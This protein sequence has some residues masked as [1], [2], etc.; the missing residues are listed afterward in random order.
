MTIYQNAMKE[1]CIALDLTGRVL[2]GLSDNAEGINGTLA[3]GKDQVSCYTYAM[4]GK[5]WCI[6][7]HKLSLPSHG[8]EGTTKSTS[9][10]NQYSHLLE[11]FFQTCELF[12]QRAKVP[13]PTVGSE[14]DF[15]W[16][17]SDSNEELFPDLQIKVVKEIISTGG[18][19]SS[20]TIDETSKDYLTPEEW[21]HEMKRLVEEND[22]N[23]GDNRNSNDTILIDCRNHKEYAVGHFDQAI[24]PN[25][26]IFA[27]FPKWVQENKS[28][29]KDKKV[30]MYCTGGI[31]CEKAS[32]YIRNELKD[33]SST[34]SV[35]HLQG[36]IHKY[37]DKFAGDGYFRGKNFVF[38][39]RL[40]MDAEEHKKKDDSTTTEVV[41]EKQQNCV[42]KCQYCEGNYDNFTGDRVCTVCRE[43]ALVCED[44]KSKLN[45]EF[46]CMDHMHLRYCY[47]T[48]LGKFSKEELQIQL[49]ELETK[50]DEIAV[51]K[52][53][54]QKR[55][56]LHK[57]C[58]RI[59]EILDSSPG[60]VE[61]MNNASSGCRSCG[62]EKCD[63][64]CWGVHG[65]KRKKRLEKETKKRIPKAPR[66]SANKR[67]SKMAQRQKEIEDI[68]RLKLS[69]A[70][71]VHRNKETSLRCPPPC[72]RILSSSV[73]GKW[74]GRTIKSV[75]GSEFHEFSDP[76]RLDEI[77]RHSLVQI[78][79][80]P[81]NSEEALRRGTDANKALSPDTLLKN[82][83]TI[84][85]IQHWIEPPVIVP[86]HID[87][88]C[89]QIP[90]LVCDELIPNFNVDGDH[91]D[92]TIYCCDK[93]STVP[94]HPAGPYYQNSLAFMIEA[95]EDLE[96]K[97]I[98]P[99]HRLDRCTSG[100]TICCTNSK[101]ARLIQVQMDQKAV[102][103]MYLAQVKVCT[104]L[105]S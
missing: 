30:L 3:G 58:E 57:Q 64:E 55:Q 41:E 24:D 73:K 97:S 75:L 101:I 27:Q 29:L 65:L 93:P 22:T 94:V 68:Q 82:M 23:N 76:T 38:D 100:L 40:T 47:F 4:L 86:S 37:L 85:R 46:H 72:I 5:Q 36:G 45:G 69:E 8:D 105:Y 39:R 59:Q 34:S 89:T 15:K 44:C 48:N 43:L 20:I 74:C 1:L 2:I 7:N 32:A 10:Q 17:S 9:T 80:V 78:D 83:D 79:G 63:G 81:V 11:T 50:L 51:G 90:K 18:V 96:T 21:H 60:E 26:K 16:S 52:R 12:S 87:V 84:C 13:I 28:A 31:R 54:K 19:L 6:D 71:N 35:Y 77:F 98:L 61:T 70:P 49:Q 104:L 42:G 67:P 95:Q 14:K 102:S 91:N 99:C 103:K 88:Q 56:T 66:L 92:R 33:I 53:Y 25:T 62:D